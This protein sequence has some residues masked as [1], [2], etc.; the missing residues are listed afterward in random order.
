[1]VKPGSQAWQFEGG[2]VLAVMLHCLPEA[3]MCTH[4]ASKHILLAE[5]TPQAAAHSAFPPPPY[6]AKTV[7]PALF[8][9]IL[10]TYQVSRE[11]PAQPSFSG[12]PGWPTNG[13]L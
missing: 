10:L 8:P 13:C 5:S 11:R 9:G 3:H 1:M 12:P 7:V 6:K 4:T 2:S